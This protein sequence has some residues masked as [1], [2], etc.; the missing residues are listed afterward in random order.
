MKNETEVHYQFL[1]T[2]I[3][4]RHKQHYEFQ[5]KF[6]PWYGRQT[7]NT[8]NISYIL[9]YSRLKYIIKLILIKYAHSNLLI[10][11]FKT[12]IQSWKYEKK[13]QNNKFSYGIEA[14]L[15]N[16]SLLFHMPS[17]LNAL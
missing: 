1:E 10:S 8:K 6:R 3:P 16:K 15:E 13:H 4:T 5:L 2:K 12:L 7:I 14:F 11:S 9:I 17:K